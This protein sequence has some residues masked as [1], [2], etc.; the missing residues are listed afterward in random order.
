MYPRYPWNSDTSAV[1]LPWRPCPRNWVGNTGWSCLICCS[2]FHDS[3]RVHKSRIHREEL[4]KCQSTIYLRVQLFLGLSPGH[5][6]QQQLTCSL[7]AAERKAQRDWYRQ[8]SGSIFMTPSVAFR[9]LLLVDTRGQPPVPIN[10]LLTTLLDMVKN[11][12]DPWLLFLWVHGR[13]LLMSPS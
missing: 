7:K 4:Q 13:R 9:N 12:T 1:T 8:N 2:S 11:A 6:L 3:K 10:R 5:D